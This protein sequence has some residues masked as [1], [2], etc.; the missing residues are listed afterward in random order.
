MKLQRWI[1]LPAFMALATLWGCATHAPVSE[2]LM[3]HDPDTRYR[4]TLTSGYGVQ[5]TVSPDRGVGL[6][7]AERAYPERFS[8]S[9]LNPN[10][11]SVGFYRVRYAESGR[12]AFAAT[13]GLFTAGLDATVKVSGRNYVTTAISSNAL[14]AYLLHRALNAPNQGLAG[15]FGVR[16]VAFNVVQPNECWTCIDTERVGVWSAG[17]RGIAILREEG[18]LDQGIKLGFYLGFVPAFSRPLVAITVNVGTY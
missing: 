1:A 16:R 12:Y 9:L 5:A 13:L 8:H 15:G 11:F 10:G 14:E 18:S 3:F 2:S 7:V 17:L 4:H 6:L